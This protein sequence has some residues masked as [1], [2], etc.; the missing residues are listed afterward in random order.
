MKPFGWKTF[1]VM[2]APCRS[3]AFS[4]TPEK[5]G[6]SMAKSNPASR[7]SPSTVS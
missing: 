2:S 7:V 1:G 6:R 4:P 5:G 3:S